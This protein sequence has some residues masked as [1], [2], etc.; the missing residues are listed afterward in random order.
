MSLLLEILWTKDIFDDFKTYLR[1]KLIN[2]KVTC[3]LVSNFDTSHH[4]MDQNYNSRE[5]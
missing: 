4:F 1:I 3:K 2:K 5:I